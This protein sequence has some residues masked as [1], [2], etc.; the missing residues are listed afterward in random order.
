MTWVLALGLAL[1]ILYLMPRRMGK[2]TDVAISPHTKHFAE[3]A[4]RLCAAGGIPGA[5]A[6]LR[7]RGNVHADRPAGR[8]TV[9][10]RRSEPEPR[11][12]PGDRRQPDL[13]TTV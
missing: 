5:R 11:D 9:Q 6:A 2:L 4:V 7:E 3:G 1:A 10:I 8:R 12:G 13:L